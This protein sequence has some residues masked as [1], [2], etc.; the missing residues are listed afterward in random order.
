MDSGSSQLALFLPPRNG[1]PAM[2]RLTRHVKEE[3]RS[4]LGLE[5]WLRDS[6]LPLLL[7]EGNQLRQRGLGL[8]L[9]LA[10]LRG[11]SSG[12]VAVL[13]RW[14]EEGVQ[15]CEPSLFVR[16]LLHANGVELSD[17]TPE[18]GLTGAS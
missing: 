5:G 8:R 18:A 14:Q 7:E 1:V 15:L 6:E 12:G 10:G 16:A 2:I 17:G 3:G 9:D 13:R 4:V 11:I